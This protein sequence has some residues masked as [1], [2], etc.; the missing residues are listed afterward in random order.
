MLTYHRHF[1]I[2]FVASTNQQRQL[3]A[4]TEP[5][6][7]P[8][9]TSISDPSIFIYLHSFMVFSAHFFF[10]FSSLLL[11]SP[12]N[13]ELSSRVRISRC[14]PPLL[15]SSSLHNRKRHHPHLQ[16]NFRQTF[17]FLPS[18]VTLQLPP[19]NASRLNTALPLPDSPTAAQLVSTL[20]IPTRY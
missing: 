17:L 4:E 8:P 15:P 2:F 5:L 14:H 11:L 10:S 13:T 20:V 6:L 18:R 7:T 9:L 12:R 1:F 3:S 19:L 16:H